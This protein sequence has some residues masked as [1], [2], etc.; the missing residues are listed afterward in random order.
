MWI[1]KA[2]WHSAAWIPEGLKTTPSWTQTSFP[3]YEEL[4]VLRPVGRTCGWSHA[5]P[6]GVDSGIV[7]IWKK[8]LWEAFGRLCLRAYCCVALTSSQWGLLAVKIPAGSLLGALWV[9]SRS[10]P[11]PFLS[12]TGHRAAAAPRLAPGARWL[13]VPVQL[14]QRAA[15][16]QSLCLPAAGKEGDLHRRQA[17]VPS[18]ISLKKMLARK[19][20]WEGC[21]DRSLCFVLFLL[22]PFLT[23]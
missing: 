6:V 13:R 11:V 16:E 7:F 4:P 17:Q 12:P 23:S 8:D 21:S 3:P 22:C 19:G 18:C 10:S 1:W 5:V 15:P 20:G 9:G 14:P 2:P